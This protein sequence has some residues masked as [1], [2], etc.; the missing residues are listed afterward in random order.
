M[1]KKMGAGNML[2]GWSFLVGLVLAVL[3]GL[4]FTGA[5][6]SQMLWAVFL[7]GLVVGLL[8][9]TAGETSA[10]LTSGT[11]LVLVSYLGASV[12]STAAGA[13]LGVDILVNVL[14]SILTLFV[15]ATIIVALRAVFTLARN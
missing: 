13:G 15:P 11:V 7:L 1:A 2:G 3:L 12:L 6:A 14:N 9:I 8:N 4:G 5:Y 10:F